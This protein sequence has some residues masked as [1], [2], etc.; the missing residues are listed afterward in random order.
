MA[1]VTAASLTA[2][3]AWADPVAAHV[4]GEVHL[5]TLTV[6]GVAHTLRH[7]NGTW[8]GFGLVPNSTG[9]SSHVVSAIV[10]GEEHVLVEEYR[11]NHPP[12]Y[13]SF[14]HRIRHADGTWGSA[15]LSVPAVFDVAVAAVS[16][17]LHLVHRAYG[18]DTAHMVRHADGTWSHLPALPGQASGSVMGAAGHSGELRLLVAN[19]NGGTLS[20][21]V[22]GADGAW[23]PAVDVPFAPAALGVQPSTV[24]VAQ[25]GTV[26][27]AVVRGSDGLLYHS[28]RHSNG[29]WDPFHGIGTQIPQPVDPVRDVSIAAS[30]D[31][32]HVAV[33]TGAGLFHAIRVANGAW[34]PFGDVEQE[35]GAVSSVKVTI[36]GT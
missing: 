6:S 30:L 19:P 23:S 17:E 32:L 24:D 31:A 10:A 8:D 3:Q 28:M 1:V 15:T 21:H 35:A 22:A 20:Y 18:S 9:L 33:A 14:K 4:P 16:G 27:H 7:A 13:S 34:Q 12:H 11:N 5:A 29:A 2:G 26:L 36:A 25:V